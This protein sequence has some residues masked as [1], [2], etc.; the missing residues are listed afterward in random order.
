LFLPLATTSGLLQRV[1]I[2]PQLVEKRGSGLA[3]HL[4]PDFVPINGHEFV[5]MVLIV[6]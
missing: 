4:I 5:V 2:T 6:W 3:E 1:P